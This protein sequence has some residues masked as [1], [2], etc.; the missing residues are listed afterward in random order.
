MQFGVLGTGMVGQAIASKL[1]SLGHSVM[2]GARR[3]DNAQALAWASAAGARAKAGSFA[4][5]AQFGEIVVN[6]TAGVASLEALTAAG[7][8]NLAG[9]I[10][11]DIANPIDLTSGMPPTLAFCNTESL[12]ERIQ[13][14]FPETCVVKTLNTVNAGVMVNPSLIPGPHSIFVCGNDPQAKAHVVALLESFGWPAGSIL[15]LGDISSARGT[16]MYLALWLRLW[17]ALGTGHFNIHVVRA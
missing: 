10:L 5:T 7:A 16:E 1:V 15:D 6:A 11:I 8:R 13:Q 12:G 3:A 17:G 2:M 14:A 4:D 9:K